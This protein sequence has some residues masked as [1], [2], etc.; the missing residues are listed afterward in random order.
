MRIVEGFFTL[1]R[2]GEGAEVGRYPN[3][4][5]H[6]GFPTSAVR[7][8]PLHRGVN[9]PRA[10]GASDTFGDFPCYSPNRGS[11]SER[12]PAGETGTGGFRLG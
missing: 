10:M 6:T 12:I 3:N 7:V 1:L 11:D 9:F 5:S 8:T 4:L 2:G